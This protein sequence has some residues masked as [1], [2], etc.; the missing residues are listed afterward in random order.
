MEINSFLCFIEKLKS[1]QGRAQL[2]YTKSC[3][4]GSLRELDSYQEYELG[5]IIMGHLYSIIYSISAVVTKQNMQT[6]LEWIFTDY[7]W[8]NFVSYFCRIFWFYFKCADV[9][10]IV[11]RSKN[12]NRNNFTPTFQLSA[13]SE[14]YNSVFI[15]KPN[16]QL[17]L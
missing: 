8:F 9:A 10:K 2:S 7:A 16:T 1:S 15:A 6:M 5:K 13:F 17:M 4:S 3:L 12:W 11:T 14:R